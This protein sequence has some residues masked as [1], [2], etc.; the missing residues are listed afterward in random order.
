[1]SICFLSL[2]SKWLPWF[3][4]LT[5]SKMSFFSP[6]ILCVWKQ[7]WRGQE[8]HSAGISLESMEDA[9]TS[10]LSIPSSSR[11]HFF[12]WYPPPLSPGI[13]EVWGD[14]KPFLWYSWCW[15]GNW[16]TLGLKTC[17]VFSCLTTGARIQFFLRTWHR[18]VINSIFD[19]D[20]TKDSSFTGGGCAKYCSL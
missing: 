13:L 15:L 10:P 6:S 7:S 18:V 20:F 2:S 4:H 8:S 16:P 19:Y 17:S 12:P 3:A 1:M 5:Y 9:P 14:I 11:T